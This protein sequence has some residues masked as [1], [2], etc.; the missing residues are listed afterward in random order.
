MV[1][2]LIFILP[3]GSLSDLIPKKKVLLVIP[4]ALMLQSTIYLMSAKFQESHLAILALGSSVTGIFGDLQGGLSLANSFMAEMTT[5]GTVRTVRMTILTGLAYVGIGI[6]ATFA[7][8]LMDNT[9]L[10]VYSHSV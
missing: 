2:A 6:G 1:P 10:N 5:V 3:M 7:G 4:L 9:T 8:F